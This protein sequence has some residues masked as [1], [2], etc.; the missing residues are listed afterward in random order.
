MMLAVVAAKDG[1]VLL[2]DLLD[3]AQEASWL[4][5]SSFGGQRLA[6]PMPPIGVVD[7]G[8]EDL[9]GVQSCESSIDE[10]ISCQPKCRSGTTPD[11]RASRCNRDAVSALVL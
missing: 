1:A 4:A 9:D 3:S 5:A 6:A 10:L 7:R 8:T 11:V 2:A